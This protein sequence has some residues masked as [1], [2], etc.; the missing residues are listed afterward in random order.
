MLEVLFQNPLI[1]DIFNN[2]ANPSQ[3]E[4][5]S[6]LMLEGLRENMDLMVQNLVNQL[7]SEFVFVKTQNEPFI[8][9]RERSRL[10]PRLTG[11]YI[12]SRMNPI[13]RY[14]FKS[15]LEGIK[16]PKL[17][18]EDIAQI[19]FNKIY[20]DE[21]INDIPIDVAFMINQVFFLS[22]VYEFEEYN[23]MLTGNL[24]FLRCVCPSIAAPEFYQIMA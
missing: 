11:D 10:A 16:D 14:H 23:Y 3:L 24:I 8:F 6:F 7:E 19:V 5:Y 22:G 4:G 20:S 9:L 17:T 13:L 1:S 18:D 12:N 15:M 2:V 21:F